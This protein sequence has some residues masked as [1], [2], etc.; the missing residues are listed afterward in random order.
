M[1][2]KKLN[3]ALKE[4]QTPKYKNAFIIFSVATIICSIFFTLFYCFGK[5]TEEIKI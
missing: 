1:E 5:D 2:E 3:D 4:W